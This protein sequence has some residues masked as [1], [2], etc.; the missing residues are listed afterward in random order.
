[1]KKILSIVLTVIVAIVA[2]RVLLWILNVTI[3]LVGNL[4]FLALIIAAAIWLVRA[5][6]SRS[7]G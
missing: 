6:R 3:S 1:M 7:S 5:L 2:I 4:I